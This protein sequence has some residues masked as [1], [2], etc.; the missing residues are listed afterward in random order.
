MDSERFDQITA[1]LTAQLSRRRS[2]GL[3]G[4]LGVASTGMT[5]EVAVGKKRRRKK[6]TPCE[7]DT[8]CSDFCRC[9]PSVKDGRTV[10][11]ENAALEAPDGSCAS[12]PKGTVACELIG[13]TLACSAACRDRGRF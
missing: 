12:C 5:A 8:D 9:A 4:V 1:R 3:L 6:L 13:E 10:C 11:I 7:V 2:L